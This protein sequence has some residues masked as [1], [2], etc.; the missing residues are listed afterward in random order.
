MALATTFERDALGRLDA[1]RS[2]RDRFVALAFCAADMLVETDA[3]ERITF[4]AG[5]TRALTGRDPER[6]IGQR[7]TEL[8]A[9]EDRMYVA[10]LMAGMVALGRFDAV[11]AHLQGP[12]GITP[13][14][15]LSGHHV[16]DMPGRFFFALKVGAAAIDP[17]IA[18]SLS[19]DPQSGLLDRESFLLVAERQ[20]QRAKKTGED[21]QLTLFRMENLP[22]LR[23]RLDNESKG[24]LAATIG[25]YLRGGAVG[26]DGAGQIDENNYGVIHRHQVDIER[27]RAKIEASARAADPEGTGVTVKSGTIDADVAAMSDADAL[28]VLRYAVDRFCDDDKRIP[29]F[30]SL[31][32]GLEHLLDHTAQRVAEL[33]RTISGGKFEVVFQPI[34]EVAI[35]RIHHF[36]A[37]VRFPVAAGS[38]PSPYPTIVFA[39]A[40]GLIT[41]FDLAMCRRV[42]DW[43]AR[44]APGRDTPIVAVNISGRSVNDLAFRDSLLDLLDTHPDERKRVMFEITESVRIPDLA[45]ANQFIRGLR[46]AGHQV[47]LDDF[48]AGSAALEYLR[49]LEVDIVKIDGQYLQNAADDA[50]SKVFL[51]AMAALC[52][53]LEIDMIAEMVEDERYL[54]LL[55]ECGIRYAQ[56]YHYGRPHAD[57]HGFL[58]SQRPKRIAVRRFARR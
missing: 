56:G 49:R 8:V 55:E 37:L 33:R 38:D 21:L 10:E 41:D 51:K 17:A 18:H 22:E 34:V 42:L 4:A 48:G 47:C 1:L 50:K 9:P 54:A 28:R 14:L 20:A 46:K 36:E 32:H 35:Q 31:S 15:L 13:P 40:T 19:R 16:T 24:R 3:D 6:L 29:P 58:K 27:L 5:A 26:G 53:D 57:L 43:L 44:H 7:L 2:E 30:D 45:L 11:M 25:A 52:H 39:E 12:D 23:T